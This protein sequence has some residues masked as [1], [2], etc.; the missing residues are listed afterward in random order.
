MHYIIDKARIETIRAVVSL[1]CMLAISLAFASTVTER[2][3]PVQGDHQ[4]SLVK[5]T[6]TAMTPPETGSFVLENALQRLVFDERGCLR[7]L[8]NRKTGVGY[9]RAGAAASSPFV[10]DVYRADGPVTFTDR[11]EEEAGGFSLSPPTLPPGEAHGELAHIG[12]AEAKS[13][14]VKLT[15]TRNRQTLSCRYTLPHGIR[16]SFQVT[17]D[18]GAETACWRAKLENPGLAQRKNS[19][20]VF[21]A[22]FPILSNLC[23]D[24]A[25][26]D[27]Y[28][29]RPLAQG[30]LVRHPAQ[31][32]FILK[33]NWVGKD[34]P[35]MR[36]HL[37]TYPG[38]ASMPWMDIYVSRPGRTEQTSGLYLASYDPTF[39]QIDLVTTP[40]PA[41][42]TLELRIQT[43]VGL[44]PG[45]RWTSQQFI[46]GVHAGDWHWAGD[47][48]RADSRAWLKPNA[49]PDWV[50]QSDGWFGSGAPN[51]QFADLPS[52]LD[53]ARWL[54][55]DY[56][57][58]WSEMIEPTDVNGRR[59]AYY[60]FFLPD[61]A[62]GG[63]EALRAAAREVRRRGGHLG[64]YSNIW[65]FDAE[66][67]G[68]LDQWKERIPRDVH[69]PDWQKEFR[70][71]GSVFPDGHRDEGNY[72]NGYAG[73]CLC[74]QGY[75]DY[76]THWIADKYVKDY[77]VDAWY[78]DSC[79]VTIF[80]AARVCFS[81]EHG[82]APHGVGRGIIALLQELRKKSDPTLHLA[83][84]SETISDVLMQYQS[85][86]LGIEMVAG[87]PHPKP[88]I[89]AYTFPEQ[90][91]FSGSCNG[92]GAGLVHYYPDMT[93]PTRED[94]MNRVFLMGYRFDILGY[95]LHRTEEFSQ[96]LR[97]LI[98]L[99][100]QIKTALYAARFRDETGLGPRPE[101]VDVKVFQNPDTHALVLTIQDRRAIQDAFPLTLSLQLLGDKG[102]T[103]ATLY[104]LDGTRHDV[105][106]ERQSG[107]VT[108]HIP[109]F[110]HVPAAIVA[111]VE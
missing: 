5:G 31:E 14:A 103:H 3:L 23:L 32:S 33:E 29:A 17:L 6:A 42:D 21:R 90:I 64:F 109:A 35:P 16:F 79:P 28:L 62:R 49:P 69:I 74:A 20:R 61:P 47:R 82:A 89:Y 110:T 106:V 30:E 94:A 100:Q 75:R 68:A 53:D 38:W 8:L 4:H 54:G 80:N 18:D 2:S 7:E 77:G 50:R 81:R 58:C 11:E 102:I 73:M 67:P 25:P 95:P 44:E 19:R 57:Q 108:L 70:T 51:Y 36:T 45:S 1:L 86:A 27:N 93:H 12:V 46:T 40:N 111:A 52:M 13:H 26:A 101:K 39:Q 66:L 72:V 48:Y 99:R 96:Y 107:S 98:A 24:G 10:L 84:S 22:R 60:C 9:V 71:F 105:P 91:I 56:L 34:Q 63:E 83:I 43:F 85:H 41:A 59:K 55:L 88:E 15:R 104:T 87:F 37:L 97:S 92:A 65:T 76:L 78:L